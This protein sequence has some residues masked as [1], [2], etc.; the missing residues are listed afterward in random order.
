[1]KLLGVVFRLFVPTD[2]S[3]GDIPYLHVFRNII[4][5][6]HII[7]IWEVKMK[8]RISWISLSVL[9]MGLA[10][11]V[12]ERVETEESGEAY[13]E[14]EVNNIIERI[15][16]ESGP[17]L[18]GLLLSLV[19]FQQFAVEPVT[20][21]LDHENPK[22]RSSAAFV[23]GQLKA[24]EALERLMELTEDDNKLVRYEAARAVLEIGLWDTV[25]FLLQGLDDDD[26]R[27]RFLCFEAL[28]RNTGESHG[29]DYEAPSEERSEA[30]GR[31]QAWWRSQEGAPALEGNLATG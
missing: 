3:R 12:T 7:I 27:V 14:R 9:L 11:C 26:P 8:N 10:G 13:L 29:Y 24:E 1:L 20:G 21:V 15:P 5:D 25:P 28:N 22:V 16:Y 2:V 18:H 31:W 6:A 23:L 19:A 17:Q 30:V 4:I